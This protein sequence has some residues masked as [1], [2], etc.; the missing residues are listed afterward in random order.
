[1]ASRLNGHYRV[2]FRGHGGFNA[3]EF[4][5]DAQ[6]FKKVKVEAVDI[7][8][9]LQDYG[10]H[11]PTV[12]WPIANTLMVEPTESENRD[13]LD[14]YCDALIGVCVCV[15]V[16]VCACVCVCVCVC[17]RARARE[18]GI[19][20][21]T[22]VCVWNSVCDLDVCSVCVVYWCVHVCVCVCVDV[23]MYMHMC[24]CVFGLVYCAGMHECNL[25]WLSISHSRG[26]QGDRRRQ[27]PH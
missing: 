26:D 27:I 1:M 7:A 19:L 21:H 22:G 11:A 6:Q 4:I 16:C 15:C 24:M 13:M 8:K 12:S 20:M 25:T 17:V 18:C 5:L 10:C 9:R 2:L 14:K 3:H 23:C